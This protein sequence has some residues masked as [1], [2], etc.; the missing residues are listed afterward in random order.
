MIRISFIFFLAS[1]IFL[2]ANEI[3]G[4]DAYE[5]AQKYESENKTAEALFWYKKAAKSLKVADAPPLKLENFLKQKSLYN[6]KNSTILDE[7]DYLKNLTSEYEDNETKNTVAQIIN[8]LF[9]IETYRAN[10]FLPLNYDFKSHKDNRKHSETL[11][12][13]SFKKDLI[14]NFFGFNEVFGVAYTQR[15]WWQLYKHS[16]PFRETNYLPEFYLSIPWYSNKSMIKN[17]KLGFL[18]ESNGQ[19]GK[20]SRSWNRLYAEI[21]LQYKG[22]FIAPRI[23]YRLK[24]S[25]KYDDNK[26]ILEYIGYGD[27]ILSYPHKNQLFTLLLRNNFDFDDNK[28]AVQFDW[29]FPIA[30]SKMFGYV[31][32]FDGYGES[33]IDY[34]KKI[35]RIG[36]G[37]ALSR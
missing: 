3:E 33:L 16:S 37:L 2:A 11:F 15:S 34:N 13:L 22:V 31:R 28:G 5:L 10:Y 6:E 36:I 19:G 20:N 30:K 26:D 9:D 7:K 27:L 21:I 24:E 4:K 14:K 18:H 25:E 32:Y 8:S 17:Y 12:Q 1:I 35:R 23:W 29:T